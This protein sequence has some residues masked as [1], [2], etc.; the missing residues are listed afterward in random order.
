MASAKG[1]AGIQRGADLT[2]TASDPKTQRAL[3]AARERGRLRAAEI[4]SGVDMLSTD[5]FAEILGTTGATVNTKR[6]CGQLLGLNGAKRGVRFP[7]WQLDVEGKPYGA[8]SRLHE[9]LGGPWAVFRFLMQ[10]HGELGGLTGREALGR[11]K[12]KAVLEA[13]ESVGRDFT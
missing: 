11:G 4:L 10:P 5:A 2:T 3:T 6:W 7:I 13:A 12:V 1:R 8:I 9:L